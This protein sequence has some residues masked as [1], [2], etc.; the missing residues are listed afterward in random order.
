MKYG[1]F[2]LTEIKERRTKK[3]RKDTAQ[4]FTLLHRARKVAFLNS[5]GKKRD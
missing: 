3:I 2:C 1:P 4:A 5:Q